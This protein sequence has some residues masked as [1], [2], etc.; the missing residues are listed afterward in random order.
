MPRVP[1]L[2]RLITERTQAETTI[3]EILDAVG[4]DRDVSDAEMTQVR[5]I[6]ERVERL[7]E[8]ISP[9]QEL[10]D[11]M[12]AHA[13]TVRHIT[14]TV[15]DQ[16]QRSAG[17]ADARLVVRPREQVYDS[18]GEFM[19]DYVRSFEHSSRQMADLYDPGAAQ[20]VAVALG[21]AAGDVAAGDH[22]TTA[23]TPGILPKNIIGEIHNDID[24]AR[25]L[26]EALGVKDLAGIPGKQFSRPVLT[27]HPKKAGT[28]G[29][30]AAEKAE[31][32]KSQ[33]TIGGVD[34]TKETFLRW[35]NVSRQEID[36]TS[37]A[38]WD[39][40]I[41]EMVAIYGE[42]TEDDTAAKLAAA[43]TQTQAVATDDIAGWI[44]GLYAA[45]TK[46]VTANNT[47]RASVR[48]VPDGLFVSYDMD[49]TLGA[50]IDTHLALNVNGVGS[51]SL[52][53][54]GGDILR[55]PRVMSPGLPAGT[56]ILGRRT[57]FEFYE[58]RVGL[59]QAVEPEVLGVKISYGSYTAAGAIDATLFCKVTAPTTP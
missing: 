9:L 5:A 11:R 50:L 27:A 46:V 10:Q 2:D 16:R 20:R 48:R 34:F 6:R 22:Q 49:N 52:T 15:P 26:I 24:G 59:L 54:F 39:T 23:D 42:D 18:A 32:E 29:K 55:L 41:A 3:T 4:E 56:V 51:A 38:V 14:P 57:G 30:Q 45:K 12:D 28:S 37:P 19:A 33:V 35:M 17:P 21:R 8:Q 13:E 40:L 31:A 47:K 58:Q 44:A 1:Q 53:T 36:W 7:D 25:P 43:V